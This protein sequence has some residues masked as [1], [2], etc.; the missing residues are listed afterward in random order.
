MCLCNKEL[1]QIRPFT[2]ELLRSIQPFFELIAFS[3]LPFH[4]LEQIIEFLELI[5][6]KPIIDL[7]LNKDRKKR[8]RTIRNK[9]KRTK[10]VVKSFFQNIVCEL[11]FVH[12]P[13]VDEYL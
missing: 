2:F 5:L 8:R 3:N 9:K 1:Y 13:E 10:M 11:G 4:K 7:L 6:N 12:M